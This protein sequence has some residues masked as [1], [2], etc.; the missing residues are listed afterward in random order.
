MSTLFIVAR[1][2]P[3]RRAAVAL[4]EAGRGGEVRAEEGLGARVGPD[5]LLKVGCVC[6]GG[7]NEECEAS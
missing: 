4:H 7:G 1:V 3:R 6:G 2:V 5:N